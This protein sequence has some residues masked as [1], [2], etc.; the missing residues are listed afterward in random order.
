M[1]ALCL[2]LRTV[3]FS[4]VGGM[5]LPVVSLFLPRFALASAPV[6]LCPRIRV[7]K[8]IRL[9]VSR[10]RAYSTMYH[11][12]APLSLF[13]SLHV[14]VRTCPYAHSFSRVSCL[15]S[16]CAAA[17]VEKNTRERDIEIARASSVDPFGRPEE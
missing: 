2:I 5:S 6:F 9:S 16:S 12:R 3:L 15:S 7:C 1:S 11:T 17:Y 8:C 14:Y 4:G 13:L 10:A